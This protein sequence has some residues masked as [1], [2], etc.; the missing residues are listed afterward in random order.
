MRIASSLFI[1]P[2]PPQAVIVSAGVV[3]VV[4]AF[5]VSAEVVTL[6]GVIAPLVAA[7]TSAHDPDWQVYKSPVVTTC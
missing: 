3:G 6:D 2:H 5:T 7:A 4:S 1:H